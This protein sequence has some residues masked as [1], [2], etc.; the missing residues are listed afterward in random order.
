MKKKIITY[1][2]ILVIKFKYNKNIFINKKYNKH[3]I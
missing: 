1:F 2:K 3:K